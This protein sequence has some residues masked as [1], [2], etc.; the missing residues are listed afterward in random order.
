MPQ[1]RRAP[2]SADPHEAKHARLRK[3][4]AD[5]ATSGLPSRQV[6]RLAQVSEKMVRNVRKEMAAAAE[7]EAAKKAKSRP[8]KK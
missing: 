7:A 4:L 6:A 2:T 8:K 3:Y 5:P 1:G